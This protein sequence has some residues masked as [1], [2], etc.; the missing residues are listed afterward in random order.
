MFLLSH[1]CACL[2]ILNVG[3][4]LLKTNEHVLVPIAIS[5]SVLKLG[6]GGEFTLSTNVFIVPE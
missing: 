6:D 2:N 5:Y 1:E 4:L 3:P